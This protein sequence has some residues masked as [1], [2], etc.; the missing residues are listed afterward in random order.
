MNIQVYLLDSVVQVFLLDPVVDFYSVDSDCAQ[1]T[2]W[3]EMFAGSAAYALLFD[4]GRYH[5]AVRV[6]WI[7]P[8]HR[9]GS[10]RAVTCAVAAADFV[11]VH[12]A[13]VKAYH[14]MSDLD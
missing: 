10:D 6:L 4:D 12:D 1:W 5:E 11:S 9:D 13:V 14:C 7:C 3:T 2:G 8:D